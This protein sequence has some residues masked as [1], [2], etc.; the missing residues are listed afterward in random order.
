MLVRFIL[1]L[2]LIG[3]LRTLTTH[4][5][6]RRTIIRE[7]ISVVLAISLTL[8][9]CMT[10]QRIQSGGRSDCIAVLRMVRSSTS[11]CGMGA[12]IP[13][14]GRI[15]VG[16]F[17]TQALEMAWTLVRAMTMAMIMRMTVTMSLAV[18]L[19]RRHLGRS[20]LGRRSWLDR[21]RLLSTGSSVWIGGCVY[22]ASNFGYSWWWLGSDGS[23]FFGF[24]KIDPNRV[25][26]L[27]GVVGARFHERR[28][29]PILGN[30]KRVGIVVVVGIGIGVFGEV[31]RVV[32]G[33][34]GDA[35]IAGAV[36][37]IRDVCG[38]G[39]VGVVGV[40]W[41][42]CGVGIVG[43]V[44]VD[45]IIIRTADT[46]SAAPIDMCTGMRCI[47]RIGAK[48]HV[49]IRKGKTRCLCFGN[50]AGGRGSGVH[51]S[52]A[53]ADDDQSVGWVVGNFNL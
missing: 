4:V 51:G 35:R 45:A 30:R 23:R 25:S 42:I 36:G 12:R 1:A 3:A 26:V 6:I 5:P 53:D 28:Q 34:V 39:A 43:V 37:V 32:D 8:T 16:P 33:A 27:E 41:D 11:V 46:T 17:E 44:G 21:R 13:R 7:A 38:V 50:R 9:L 48:G 40:I 20:Q 15:G 10:S 29:F 14:D 19:L 31:I 52:D 18:L 47:E 2:V 22:C 49:L 24:R